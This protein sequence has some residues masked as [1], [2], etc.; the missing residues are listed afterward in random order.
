MS[1]QGVVLLV[2][3]PIPI[4]AG[5]YWHWKALGFYRSL[6]DRVKGMS[7][8]W[9][10]FQFQN[11]GFAKQLP[12]YVDVLK[13]LPEDQAARIITIRRQMRYATMTVA[14]WSLLFFLSIVLSFRR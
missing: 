7:Y 12:G 5:F 14:C 6:G 10:S 1:P 13:G 9:F 8:Y 3:M 11:P 4:T 2:S